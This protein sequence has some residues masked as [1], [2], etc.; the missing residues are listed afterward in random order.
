[1]GG[2]HTYICGEDLM[3]NGMWQEMLR[4]VADGK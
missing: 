4:R 3:K 1:M 2:H